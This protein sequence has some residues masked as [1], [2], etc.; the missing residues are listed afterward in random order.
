MPQVPSLV[1]ATPQ[2]LENENLLP[3]KQLKDMGKL[4]SWK[5]TMNHPCLTIQDKLSFN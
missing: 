1:F 5:G 3:D 4:D 2:Y